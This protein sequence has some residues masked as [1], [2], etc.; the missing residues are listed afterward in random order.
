MR[1][2]RSLTVIAVALLLPSCAVYMHDDRPYRHGYG[3]PPGP[4]DHMDGRREGIIGISIVRPEGAPRRGPLVVERVLPGGPADEANIRPG[5][6]I[7][8][9]DGESTHGMTVT[10]AAR[11]IRGRPDTSVELRVDSARGSRLITLVRVAPRGACHGKR[12]KERCRR[13]RH[14]EPCREWRDRERMPPPPP[15]PPA[16]EEEVWP[17]TKPG[18]QM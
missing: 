2:L 9:I 18:H 3:Y 4:C 5:D 17:P 7:H 6:S 11:L 8:A 1:K 14:G 13:C 10:E 12:C 15:P 16:P